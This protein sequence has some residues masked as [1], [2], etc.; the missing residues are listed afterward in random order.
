M[1]FLKGSNLPRVK[2]SNQSAILRMIYYYG[3]I[4]R[5]EIA[6]KLELTLPTV[7]TNINKM[8]EEGLV[9]Q[10]GTARMTGTA[11]GRRAGL[12]EINAGSE[13]FVGAELVGEQWSVCVADFC[14]QPLASQGGTVKDKSYEAVMRQFADGYTQCLAESRKR[15][16]DICGVGIG[17][18]GLIDRENGILWMNALFQ[19][20][21]K[22]VRRD[23]AAL[24][25]YEG[26]ITVE[27]NAAA[28][29]LCA[30]I[31]HR[32]DFAQGKSLA[33]LLVASGIACPVFL[34]DSGYRGSVVGTGEAGHM[35]IDPHGRFCT[36]GNRGCLEAYA[37]ECSIINECINEIR[38]ERAVIL[39]GL[40]ADCE[41]PTMEEILRAQDEGDRDVT[42]VIEEAIYIL[43]IAM[44]NIINFTRPD[45]MLI[46]CR[47]FA[48]ERNRNMLLNRSKSALCN[49]TYYGTE[50]RFSEAGSFANA[51]GGVAVAVDEK[52]ENVE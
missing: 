17:L 23:F 41:K 45:T 46:D 27:N 25:G 5:A 30:Q 8:M 35:V 16:E 47:L 21:D 51:S 18:P 43:A 49:P 28:R 33:Y 19:W 22:K 29:G 13:F 37:S 11:N 6:E 4:R 50:I 9:R 31:F 24:T 26:K 38:R 20:S 42:R 48:S 44:S 34:N 7:T 39:R 32:K 14:G 40:C 10:V 3:P 1:Q 52:L 12:L 15:P 2:S 36:C